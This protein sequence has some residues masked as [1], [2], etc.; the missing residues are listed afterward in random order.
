MIKHIGNLC[1][2]DRHK[3]GSW[4]Q[5]LNS[6]MIC[7]LHRLLLMLMINW[8]RFLLPKKDFKQRASIGRFKGFPFGFD[9]S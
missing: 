5:W 7:I 2:Q 9:Y 3:T 8:F 1:L 4:S 6:W